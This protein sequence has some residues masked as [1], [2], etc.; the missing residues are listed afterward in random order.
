MK[1]KKQQPSRVIQLLVFSAMVSLAFTT[2]SEADSYEA[3]LKE[4][5]A[6]DKDGFY[7]EAIEHWEKLLLSLIH[8]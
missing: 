4:A 7:E 1:V 6:L 2:Y 3:S 8:I 5:L